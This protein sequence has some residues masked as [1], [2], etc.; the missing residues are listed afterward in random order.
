[1]TG[2]V[3]VIIYIIAALLFARAAVQLLARK[4]R[5]RDEV[6]TRE[7]IRLAQVCYPG[8]T[9]TDA[10]DKLYEL[11]Y[12]NLVRTKRQGGDIH[13]LIHDQTLIANER[14][15]IW[16]EQA[17]SRLAATEGVCYFR[18]IH[19]ASTPRKPPQPA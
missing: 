15:R 10:L 3:F 17:D 1:M 2:I 19:G 9:T 13:K 11:T 4:A 12:K 5:R 18:V 6:R 7:L 16:R 14:L 8:L